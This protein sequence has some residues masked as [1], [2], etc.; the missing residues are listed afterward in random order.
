M[1][2]AL[3]LTGLDARDPLAYLAALG[4]LLAA[5]SR[6]RVQGLEPP[7]MSF[8][9]GARLG[10]TLHGCAQ[11][12]DALLDWLV[13][14]LDEL[15]GRGELERDPFLDFTYPDDKGKAVRDLKPPPELFRA[16]GEE[17]VERGDVHERRSLDWA[18]ATLTDVATDLSGNAKP[19]ALHFTAGQQRF[20]NVAAELLDGAGGNRAQRPVDRDDLDA[21]VFGPWAGDRELKVFSWSPCQDRAYALRAL[22]PS[23]DTKL[24]DPGVDWLALRG[25]AML[26]SA[27]VADKIGTSGVHGGWKTGMFSYPVW[28]AALDVDAV[29]SLLRHPCMR[30]VEEI[31]E[32]SAVA[33]RTL[34]RGVEVL[35]C[36]IT[37]SEQGGYGAF[38]RPSRR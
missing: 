23:G 35:S 5:S 3:S 38:S 24:G 21:A 19:F 6:C 16:F 8:E 27:P 17:L 1:T 33:R 14:D 26:S 20:L 28:S 34:P 29:R 22:D 30:D 4:C 36:R 13:A 31:G 15:A 11:T 2:H 37:R 10:P 32:A 25:I 18:A 12:R 7:R 9:L